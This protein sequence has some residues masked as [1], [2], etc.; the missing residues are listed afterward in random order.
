MNDVLSMSWET[1]MW[2]LVSGNMMCLCSPTLLFWIMT[3]PGLV[4]YYKCCTRR[5]CSICSVYL[6][7]TLVSAYTGLYILNLHYIKVWNFV[8]ILLHCSDGFLCNIYRR[9]RAIESHTVLCYVRH[10]YNYLYPVMLRYCSNTAVK[11]C[12]S[13]TLCAQCQTHVAVVVFVLNDVEQWVF[14][15]H[16]VSTLY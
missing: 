14:Y 1:W 5:D 10:N 9:A 4:G 12:V 3:T 15:N 7:K 2:G 6:S 11:L 8:R 13:C 16:C